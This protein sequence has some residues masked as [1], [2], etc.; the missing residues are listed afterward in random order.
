[1]M[2]CESAS[3]DCAF[4]AATRA[5]AKSA[6]EVRPAPLASADQHATSGRKG[7]HGK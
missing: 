5:T 7:R 3:D 4:P 2:G 6:S 1:M